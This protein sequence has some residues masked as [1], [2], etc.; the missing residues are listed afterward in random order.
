MKRRIDRLKNFG[1][2][3]ESSMAEAGI[4]G[5]M[6]ELQ[7]AFGLAQLKHL[8][9]AIHAR[10]LLDARYREGLSG[11]NGIRVVPLIP[12]VEQNYS[13]FPILVGPEYHETRDALCERLKSHGIFARRY[14]HPLISNLLFYKDLPSASERYLPV[15]NRC[16]EQVLCL[17]L[18][19]SL[20]SGDVDS[21]I[22]WIRN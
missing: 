18:Y 6:N 3:S 13:Y 19:P 15:A 20:S 14:F 12:G 2:D 7:A 10:Q 1:L 22:E 5:K 4:N 16:A 17:P 21:I 8:E 11:I 9:R